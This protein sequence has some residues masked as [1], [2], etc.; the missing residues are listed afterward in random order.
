MDKH[1]REREAED[2]EKKPG[3]QQ[4]ERLFDPW[5]GEFNRDYQKQDREFDF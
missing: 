4:D 1:Q 3:S 5:E 2:Q